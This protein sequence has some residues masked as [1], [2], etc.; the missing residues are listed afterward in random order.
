MLMMSVVVC[1]VWIW[2]DMVCVVVFMVNLV[3]IFVDRYMKIIKFFCYY[4]NMIKKCFL[5]VICGVWVYVVILVIFVIIKWLG[6]KGV[7]IDFV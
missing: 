4:R 3:V 1:L 6:V 7:V 2:M 5:L